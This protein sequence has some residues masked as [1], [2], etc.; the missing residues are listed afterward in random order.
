[1]V[2]GDELR[3]SRGWDLAPRDDESMGTVSDPLVPAPSRRGRKRTR[4][5]HPP[6][7]CIRFAHTVAHAVG[8]SHSHWPATLL[9]VR[10]I[11][12][13]RG[14]RRCISATLQPK[15][16]RAQ[17]RARPRRAPPVD[18][19]NPPSS[20]TAAV[21]V[22][23]H[24]TAAYRGMCSAQSRRPRRVRA[25]HRRAVARSKPLLE[26]LK[27]HD[28]GP[29]GVIGYANGPRAAVHAAV[30][31]TKVRAMAHKT[32]RPPLPLAKVYVPRQCRQ[33]R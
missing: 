8:S 26:P 14:V 6:T 5:G 23:S 11:H 9:C 21:S 25:T 3:L 32:M 15:G 10:P 28:G 1:M 17:P 13:A 33:C 24:H 22:F 4:T 27:P 20:A 2:R 31:R 29:V 30:T 16:M 12:A 18:L 19:A 7:V